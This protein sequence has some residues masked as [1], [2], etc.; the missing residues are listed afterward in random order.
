M[1]KRNLLKL[2]DSRKGHLDYRI[3]RDYVRNGVV[4]IP[5]RVSDYSDVISPYS[6]KNYE[7]LNPEFVDYLKETA[8]LTPSKYPLVLNI[9]GDCLSP[10]EKQTIEDTIIDDFA[11]DLGVVEKEERRHTKVFCLMTIGLLLSGLLLWFTRSLADEPREMIY[12][13]FWFMGDTLCDY[14][15]M[16][17]Y[18]LRRDRRQAGRL[19]SIQ[20]FF[21]DSY[22]GQAYTDEDVKKLYSE[23]E[24]SV[25]ETILEKE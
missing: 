21:S 13:L 18:D 11:Y 24:K 3:N 7:T 6:V 1:I 25:N 17:G 14:L 2:F 12:I 20:V 22:D 8:Q 10:E 19:A 5:C 4:T 16:T 15:F 23:I 9:I